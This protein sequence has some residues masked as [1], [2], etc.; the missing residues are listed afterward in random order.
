MKT[1]RFRLVRLIGDAVQR[2]DYIGTRE[3]VPSGWSIAMW[4]AA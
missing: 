3:R 1:Y 2:L 4:R